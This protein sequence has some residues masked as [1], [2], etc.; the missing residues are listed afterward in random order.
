V[1]ALLI[2]KEILIKNNTLSEK[3]REDIIYTILNVYDNI[4]EKRGELTILVLTALAAMEYFT[5]KFFHECGIKIN[6]F[7]KNS[8]VFDI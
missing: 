4:R 3:G 7:T 2:E 8:K 6:D 5:I 1:N